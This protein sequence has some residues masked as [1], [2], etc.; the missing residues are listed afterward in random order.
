VVDV[1][2]PG[3]FSGCYSKDSPDRWPVNAR[4]FYAMTKCEYPPHIINIQ[5]EMIEL[6]MLHNADIARMH[7][8]ISVTPTCLD[9]MYYAKAV[10]EYSLKRQAKYYAEKGDL[11]RLNQITQVNNFDEGI[12]L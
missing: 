6:N 8:C 11:K 9:L 1:V 10:K 4:I 7:H 3:D 12:I 2:S 5:R